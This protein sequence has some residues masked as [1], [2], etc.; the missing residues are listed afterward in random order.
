MNEMRQTVGTRNDDDAL[1]RQFC[2]SFEYIFG[3]SD[4]DE[5]SDHEDHDLCASKPLLSKKS[6]NSFMATTTNR[7]I[8]ST[9]SYTCEDPCVFKAKLSFISTKDVLKVMI[10]GSKDFCASKARQRCR[11]LQRPEMWDRLVEEK[12]NQE[13]AEYESMI[14]QLMEF[15]VLYEYLN[16]G[17]GGEPYSNIKKLH[18]T[19]QERWAKKDRVLTDMEAGVDSTEP[20]ETPVVAARPAVP[21]GPKKSRTKRLLERVATMDMATQ[22]KATSGP[23][24]SDDTST[25]G[26]E[27]DSQKRNPQEKV[28]TMNIT[29]VTTSSFIDEGDDADDWIQVGGPKP[30]KQS[31]VESS[32]APPAHRSPVGLLERH[33]SHE[34]KSWKQKDCGSYICDSLQAVA[35]GE[36]TFIQVVPLVRQDSSIRECPF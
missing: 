5:E 27:E 16:G 14:Y 6:S 12:D 25:E 21:S 11:L 10:D 13:I 17:S 9:F 23:V 31:S 26:E 33:N 20:E 7:P 32:V 36:R 4:E 3:D 24:E 28:S 34:F 35:R 1:S 22:P 18:P 8:N 15:R 29:P 19:D 2:N 30:R